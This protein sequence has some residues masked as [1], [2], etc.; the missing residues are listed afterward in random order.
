[1]DMEL[2]RGLIAQIIVMGHEINRAEGELRG[3]IDRLNQDEQAELIALM[4]IGR[5][6]FEAED[7]EAA[8]STAEA[9]ASTPCADYLIGTPHFPDHLESGAEA[10]G[11]EL[12]LSTEH[13]A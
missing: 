5:G 11:L 6:S 2:E 3:I 4:W 8:R 12:T 7:W 10:L 1:M 13:F 9:E